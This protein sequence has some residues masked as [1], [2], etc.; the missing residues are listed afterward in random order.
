[1]KFKNEDDVYVIGENNN[2]L[3]KI[4]NNKLIVYLVLLSILLTLLFLFISYFSRNDLK[5][6]SKVQ[7]LQTVNILPNNAKAPLFMGKYDMKEFLSWLSKQ[8]KYPDGYE[9]E[10]AKVVVTFVVTEKG[11]LD[12]IS[13]ISQPK[14]KIFGENVVKILQQC[15]KWESGKL[16]DGT[17]T[18]IRYTLPI[19]FKKQRTIN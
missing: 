18:P 17:P 4:G 8:I 6:E 5:E 7:E 13:I 3:R 11:T 19:N 16:A 15:P 14:D 10:D 2:R 9:L 12:S 1:M